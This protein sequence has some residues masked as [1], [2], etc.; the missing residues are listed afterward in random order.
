MSCIGVADL[1]CTRIGTKTMRKFFIYLFNG[2]TDED[3]NNYI[4][5]TSQ[6]SLRYERTIDDLRVTIAELKADNRY[7]RDLIFK[8]KNV[9][10]AEVATQG[11][12]S[13]EPI[14]LSHPSWPRIRAKLEAE[15]RARV[16]ENS[17][18]QADSTAKY[19]GDKMTQELNEEAKKLEDSKFQ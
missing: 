12:I 19:W 8:D 9:I 11:L 7:L 14:A 6:H 3:L 4:N 10:H 17:N 5:Q 18:K 13:H 16:L 15:D 1:P 2:H